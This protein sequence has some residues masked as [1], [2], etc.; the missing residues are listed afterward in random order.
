MFRRSFRLAA[1]LLILLSLTACSSASRV[2]QR[3]APAPSPRNVILL[4]ADGC[5]PASFTLARDFVRYHDGRTEL[6]LDPYQQ[7]SVRT[8]SSDSRVTDSAASATAYACGVKT[9]NGAIGMDSLGQPVATLLEA[10]EARGLATGLVATSRITHATPA[11]FSAHVPQRGQENEIA[12]QQINQGIEVLFG[13]GVSNYLPTEDGGR[14]SDGRNLLDEAAALG[15]TVARDRTAFDALDTAPALA[16]FTP[17][18]MAYALDRDPAAEPSLAEMTTKALT[19]LADDPDGFFLM[20]EGSRIDHAGHANDSAGHLRDILAYDEA[21]AAVLAFAEADGETLVVATSDHEA[22]GLTLGRQIGQRGVYA[23]NPEV[24]ERVQHTQEALVPR[25]L[26][27]DADRLALVQEGLGVTDL[28]DE[29]QARLQGTSN[30]RA[31]AAALSDI[32]GVRAILAWT[33]SGHTAVDVP[34]YAFGPGHD[35]FVGNVDNTYIGLTLAEIMGFDLEALT[36][37]LRAQ[38]GTD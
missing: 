13:G 17:S 28:T 6:V 34:L 3:E 26:E 38:A 21:V 23:W 31:L 12:A 27:P 1:P 25:L 19:L 4:I 33:T 8:F 22:G 14:R 11:S 2:A 18:H 20:I 16:L 30:G 29:E 7:G 15:Y 24:L 5:G 36:A 35:R 32:I 10:A 9:Y 37:T